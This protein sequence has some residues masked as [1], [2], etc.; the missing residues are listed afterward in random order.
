MSA[1][2]V[3]AKQALGSGRHDEPWVLETPRRSLPVRFGHAIGRFFERLLPGGRKHREER[4][5]E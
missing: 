1:V 5:W 2:V 3:S 4:G